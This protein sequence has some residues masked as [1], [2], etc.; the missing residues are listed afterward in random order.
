MRLRSF[1]CL[2][3]GRFHGE[4]RIIVEFEPKTAFKSVK[5]GLLTNRF[6]LRNVKQPPFDTF[7]QWSVDGAL[8]VIVRFRCRGDFIVELILRST[9]LTVNF[10]R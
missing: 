5:Y 9:N 3:Q 4:K 6:G 2:P 10:Y 1:L 7:L 8:I